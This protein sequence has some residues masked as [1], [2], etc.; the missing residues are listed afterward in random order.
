MDVVDEEGRSVREADGYLVVRKP[1]PGMTRGIWGDPDRY[2]STYWSKFKDVWFHG[3]WAMVDEDGY[4]FIHGRVDDVIKVSGYRIGSAEVEAALEGHPAVQEAAAVGTPHEVKGEGLSVLVV[5][6]KGYAQS[7]QL[8][9]ELKDYVA[10]Q[11]G[12][13]VRP[14]VVRFVSD[15]PKTRTGKVVRRVIRAKLLNEDL[16]DLSSIDNPEAVEA[17]AR[18]A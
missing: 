4:W 1:W 17:I 12:K 7:D 5:L 10:G 18:A 8:R 6:K 2:I 16:G 9:E 3:D 13:I 15:L 14:D 11:I